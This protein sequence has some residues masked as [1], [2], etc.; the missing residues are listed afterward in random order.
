L[1]WPFDPASRSPN[2]FRQIGMRW[3]AW[4]GATAAPIHA[5]VRYR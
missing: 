4:V 1:Y 2:S 3:V 5:G